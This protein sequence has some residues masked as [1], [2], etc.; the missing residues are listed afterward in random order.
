[1]GGG[2]ATAA[3]PEP[4]SE[5][6]KTVPSIKTMKLL[7]TLTRLWRRWLERAERQFGDGACPS[8]ADVHTFFVFASASRVGGAAW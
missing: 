5:A 6:V 8:W 3:D 7:E 2:D 4:R 1:M